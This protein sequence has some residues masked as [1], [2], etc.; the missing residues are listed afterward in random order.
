MLWLSGGQI[1]VTHTFQALLFTVELLQHS[2]KV[3]VVL[4]CFI[5][6]LL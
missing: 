3:S 6:L 1:Y 5:I 4:K 2:F